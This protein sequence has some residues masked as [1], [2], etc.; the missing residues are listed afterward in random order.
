MEALL[1]FGSVG[2]DVGCNNQRDVM[3]GLRSFV[4]SFCF[5]S[6]KLK[7]LKVVKMLCRVSKKN[8]VLQSVTA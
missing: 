2:W 5:F 8:V 3:S 1:V 4:L 6:T 7:N